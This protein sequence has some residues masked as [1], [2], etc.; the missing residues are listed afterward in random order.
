M[1]LAIVAGVSALAVTAGA[2]VA[3]EASVVPSDA[4]PAAESG[5]I[6]PIHAGDAPIET[7]S[8]ESVEQ[9]IAPEVIEQA[10]S[11][12]PVGMTRRISSGDPGLMEVTYVVTTVDG[13]V[14]DRVE[15]ATVVV[16]PATAD[17]VAVGTLIVPERP[18][19]A[20][21][22][23]RAIGKALAAQWGWTGIQWQCFDNLM[24]RE[25]GWRHTAKNPSSGAYG[26]P[27]S[28]PASKMASYGSD[29]LTNPAT[30]I[31]WGLDYVKNRYGTPCYA[32]GFWNDRYP[33]WY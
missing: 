28:L 19:I 14:V 11:Y 21:G 32:W 17:A 7:L 8:T 33:H 3:V 27:Q 18:A 9:V 31:K 4:I 22:S 23:N 25:S 12:L 24:Q 29:Y 2:V 16:E 1:R 10:D 30:Q 15:L 26:I 5:T 13:V 20:P 6:A